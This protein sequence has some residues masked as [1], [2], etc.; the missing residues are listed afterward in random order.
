MII[1]GRGRT[2]TQRPPG[3]LQAVNITGTDDQYFLRNNPDVALDSVVFHYSTY[4]AL[5]RFLGM[6]GNLDVAFDVATNFVTAWNEM[7]VNNDFLNPSTGLVDPRH[8][9]GTSNF[10][11][12][13]WPSLV[14][15]TQKQVL[16]SF[17]TGLVMPGI[18]LVSFAPFFAP[19]NL[20]FVQYYYGEE[21]NFYLYDNGA[22]NYLFGYVSI[23]IIITPITH[24]NPSHF[25]LAANL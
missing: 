24:A 7:M 5:T 4:R 1:S 11:V 15:G 14:N 9:F 21:Q 3:F 18:P 6:D 13:R 16:A 12:F 23:I 22:S 20:T 25:I 8:M 2:P 19:L 10:D 17:I